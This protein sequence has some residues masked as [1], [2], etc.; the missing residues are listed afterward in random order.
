MKALYPYLLNIHILFGAIGLL[1]GSVN[2][3][4]KKGGVIH[5]KI[6]KVFV[7]SML[8]TGLSA[9]LLASISFNIFLFIVGVFTIYLVGTGQRYMHLRNLGK[10]QRPKFVDWTLSYSMLLSGIIFILWGAYL[11]FF[12]NNLMGITMVVFGGIGIQSVRKDLQNYHSKISHKMYWLREHIIRTTAAYIA[13]L[14][15]FVVVNQE[16][17]PDPIPEVVFWLL[18][19]VV[20]TPLIFFWVRKYVKK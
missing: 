17:F 2:L 9:L 16:K 13:S 8:L 19:T 7:L 15:A 5:K 6:G 12:E 14:T 18:P 10:G 1:S 4:L 3:L 20:L 11:L